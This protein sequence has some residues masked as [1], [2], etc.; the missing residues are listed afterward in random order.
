MGAMSAELLDKKIKLSASL[1][2]CHEPKSVAKW[3][4]FLLSIL[5]LNTVVTDVSCDVLLQLNPTVC[6]S[7]HLLSSCYSIYRW[8][9]EQEEHDKTGLILK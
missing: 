3:A 1:A 9:I 6:W 8:A 2:G 7:V 5:L 4:N